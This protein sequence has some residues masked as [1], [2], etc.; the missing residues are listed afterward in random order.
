MNILLRTEAQKVSSNIIHT[1]NENIKDEMKKVAL[2]ESDK[3][4][5]EQQ[6]YEE[7]TSNAENSFNILKRILDNGEDKEE[8]DGFYFSRRAIDI[9]KDADKRFSLNSYMNL[10]ISDIL[11]MVSDNEDIKGATEDLFQEYN[12]DSAYS[13]AENFIT[14]LDK[15]NL[16]DEDINSIDD[17][18]Y[19][20]DSLDESD[21]NEYEPTENDLSNEPTDRDFSRDRDEVKS[22][23]MKEIED[24]IA[25]LYDI[26]ADNQIDSEEVE[27]INRALEALQ[28]RLNKEDIPMEESEDD[29]L[30]KDDTFR[31]KLLS[32][33]KS[34]CDYYLGNGNGHD[35]YLWAG[36]VKDQI[37]DMK[38]L[39]NSFS[40]DEKPEWLTMEDINNFEKE[41]KEKPANESAFDKL[42]NK[43]AKG[44]E[45]KG[46][47]TK[48]AKEI[49]AAVAA[50]I[51]REKLGDKA[52]NK[53]ISN[54]LKNK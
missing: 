53:K 25:D 14:I 42:E 24:K 37:E 34:D 18:E 45:K 49:G 30:N 11:N 29:F 46:M 9:L 26:L 16:S 48:K 21:N 31:Y 19:G 38:K 15:L 13:W 40:D 36:N 35:K 23:K 10:T 47:S 51:G 12:P 2:K 17:D 27:E 3:N 44:Y 54:G 5:L 32:R 7:I 43:V 8:Y 1:L 33:M 4:N 52:F 50:K 28:D 22:S 6:S 20:E 41:M 39:Y